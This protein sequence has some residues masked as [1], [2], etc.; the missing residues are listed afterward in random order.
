MNNELKHVIALLLEDARRLQQ[1][2][3]NADTEAR[4][5]EAETFLNDLRY[6]DEIIA[7]ARKIIYNYR[8]E[9]LN[10]CFAYR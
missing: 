1:I 2:E 5:V 7:D 4:I 9:D 8:K 10:Q 3:P 6:S